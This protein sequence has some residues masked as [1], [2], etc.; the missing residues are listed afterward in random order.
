[1][2][3]I[4]K[5]LLQDCSTSNEFFFSLCCAECGEK[6]QSTPAGF[7]KA[8]ITPETSG[9]LII[10]DTLYQRE[11]EAACNRALS[12][13]SKKFNL[14]PICRRLVCDHCFMICEDIDMCQ[15]CAKKLEEEGELVA[16]R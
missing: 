8:G 11:K 10:Y 1:M 13:A 9:K 15:A 2:S 6:W 12:E 4:T 3:H 16:S 5:D 7:S 14:C